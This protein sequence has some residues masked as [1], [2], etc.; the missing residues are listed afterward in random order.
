MTMPTPT[1]VDNLVTD[2]RP[3]RVNRAGH[4]LVLV[5][6][7]LLIASGVTIT[8]FGVRGDIM[9]L[10]PNPMVLLR[11]GTLLILG[12]ATTLAALSAA[13]PAVGA[14]QDGWLWALAPAMLFP[15]GALMMTLFIGGMPDNALR[16]DIARYC[17]GIGCASALLIGGALTLW[18]RQ[19]AVTSLARA[20]WLTG[21]AAGSFGT[22]AYSLHCPMNTIW[23]IGLWYSLAVGIAAV[24]GRLI[25]PRVIR[26]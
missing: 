23:F 4:G 7:S 19:G 8:V 2:L 11:G 9:T 3:V 21:L 10:D 18:L 26:W 16:P 24:A 14:R 15:I 20:G 12:L 5:L 25:V 6:V 13:K 1:L 22:F 17:L